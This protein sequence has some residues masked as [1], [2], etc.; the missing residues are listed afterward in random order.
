[1]KKLLSTL[2][3][4]TILI[5]GFSITTLSKPFEPLKSILTLEESQFEISGDIKEVVMNFRGNG[6]IVVSTG[7]EDIRVSLSFANPTAVKTG[8]RVTVKGEKLTFLVPLYIETGGYKI[9]VQKQIIGED[10]ISIEFEIKNIE[11]TKTSSTIVLIDS[12]NK[13]YKI[14]AQIIPIW[15]NLKAGDSFKITGVKKTVNIPTELTISGK[16][17]K[18]NTQLGFRIEKNNFYPKFLSNF[19]GF[20]FRNLKRNLG[21]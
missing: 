6:Y 5:L 9:Q 13:E 15:K 1:M 16:T 12:E 18:I 17:F 21:K 14:P 2:F 20:L 3:L 11:I 10:T 19:G 8:E 4:I 7:E